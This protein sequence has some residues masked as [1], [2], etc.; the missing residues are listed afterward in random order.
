MKYSVSLFLPVIFLFLLF[1]IFSSAVFA[2]GFTVTG[3]ITDTYNNSI[4]KANIS[5]IDDST[6][7]QVGNQQSSLNDGSYTFTV[8]QGVY[9]ISVQPPS[10]YAFLSKTIQQLVVNGDT[11]VNISLDPQS[12]SVFLTGTI[13]TP[14]GKPIDNLLVGL[15]YQQGSG[16]VSITT[17]TNSSGTYFFQVFPRNDYV[18]LLQNSRSTSLTPLDIPS[19]FRID[20]NTYSLSQNTTQNI[21]IPTA[22]VT[23]HIQ[24]PS[25]NPIEGASVYNF[26]YWDTNTSF[27]LPGF[28]T[29]TGTFSDAGGQPGLTDTNGNLLLRFLPSGSAINT[30]IEVDPPSTSIYYD[31][32]VNNLV[33]IDGMLVNISLSTY[34]TVSGYISDGIFGNGIPG[35]T[36]TISQ[37]SNVIFTALTD[38]IGFYYTKIP[39]GT[40]YTF[41]VHSNGKNIGEPANYKISGNFNVSGI[42]ALSIPLPEQ[43]VNISV[44]DPT[45]NLLLPAHVSVSG[46]TIILS[47]RGL[48]NATGFSTDAVDTDINNVA[49]MHLFRT[50]DST[51]NSGYTITGTPTDTSYSPSSI[52]E[53]V[54]SNMQD[55]IYVYHNFPPIV[56]PIPND[57]INE[58]DT[59]TH[60]GSFTDPDSSTSWTATVDYGDGSGSQPLVLNSDKSFT[61]SHVYTNEGAYTV[62]VSVTDNQ[63]ATGTGTST[64]TVTDVPASISVPTIP[65]NP[66]VGTSVS[67]TA[68][69]TDP[70]SSDTHVATITWGDGSSSAGT[71]TEPSG[72]TPGSVS[73]SHTYATAG[74]YIIT[75]SVIDNGE[76]ITGTSPQVVL[77]V[78]PSTGLTGSNLTG[79]NYNGANLSNQNLSGS[80][81]RGTSFNN[82][83][84]EGANLSGTNVKNASL[85]GANLTGADL[86][87]ANLKGVDLTN[88]NLT[89]ANLTGANLS[90]AIITGVIWSNTICPN[91]TNSNSD[92]NTCVGQGGGL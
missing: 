10:G 41:T 25:G 28:G 66:T 85:Q 30:V 58:G 65:S 70:D 77:A 59:Y 36:V 31:N 80:N 38:S 54:N 52:T 62:T 9:D 48:T 8:N 27:S 51:S 29:F 64:I 56:N 11:N 86:T 71:V 18:F 40:N 37:N 44:V 90:G 57:S 49:R 42:T 69:F 53:F 46:Q 22:H 78:I 60:P 34:P 7:T 15:S 14:D 39:L 55:T 13:N 82:V 17:L 83:S 19:S 84:L 68:T 67:T 2:S 61:L 72:S 3:R 75:I 24:D 16:S 20:S 74:S 5:I 47:I 92:N 1:F 6:N 87:N 23:A 88:A 63:G 76:N 21:I 43:L 89:N 33:I 12:G 45:T 32:Q 81:L 73:G 79:T 91:G 35:Q 50:S 26:N 4:G